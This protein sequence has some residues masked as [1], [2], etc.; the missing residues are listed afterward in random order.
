MYRINEGFIDLPPTWHDRTINV[1]A[2]S[3]A[4][5][6]ASLTITRDDVPWGMDFVEYVKDQEAQAAK[7]LKN[8][9]VIDRREL[10]INGAAA[11]EIESTWVAK[12]GPIH[13]IITTVQ[14]GQRAL[15][16]TASTTGKMS[17][18]Q[19]AEMRRIV[20]TLDMNQARA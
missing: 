8:F 9:E 16:L 14:M 13:Q 10:Q 17:D 5:S 7:A 4:G 6:G 18:N 20:S 19:K 3:M 2:S 1:V 11:Y 12:Q 15:I